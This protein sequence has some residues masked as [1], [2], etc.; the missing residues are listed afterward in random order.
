MIE[1]EERR[2]IQEILHK[3]DR[4]VSID[5]HAGV[6]HAG[7]ALAVFGIIR[8]IIR[9]LDPNFAERLVAR[10]TEDAA[11]HVAAAGQPREKI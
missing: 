6:L 11:A 8:D 10:A 4:H 7:T 1:P 5:V 9:P 3:A 2:L